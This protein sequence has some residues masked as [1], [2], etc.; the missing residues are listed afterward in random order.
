MEFASEE[1]YQTYTEPLLHMQI[2][3]TRWGPEVADFIEIDFKP[4]TEA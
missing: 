2:V 1:D 3:E 4:Y